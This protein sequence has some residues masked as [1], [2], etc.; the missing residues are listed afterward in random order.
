MLFSVFIFKTVYWVYSLESPQ[1]GDSNDNTKYTFTLQK[2]K[3]ILIM[4]P[5]LALL[6]TLT[7]SNFPCLEQIFVVPKVFEPLKFDC[8][9]LFFFFFFV[10]FFTFVRCHLEVV[11]FMQLKIKF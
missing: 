4:P 5:D 1:S 9:F 3:E 6:S 11:E 8:I 10:F 7:G 2:I